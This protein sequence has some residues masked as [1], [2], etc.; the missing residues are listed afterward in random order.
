MS[1][2][3]AVAQA[4][5]LLEEGLLQCSSGGSPEATA[6]LLANGFIEFGC[7][8]RVY[9]KKETVEALQARTPIRCHLTDFIARLLAPGVVLVTYRAHQEDVSAGPTTTSLRSS[10]WTL[11]EGCWQLVFHQGTPSAVETLPC[12]GPVWDPPPAGSP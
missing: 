5:R 6:A 7:S 11:N 9:D 10:I 8:G 4:L 12:D 3:P 1:T 2:D